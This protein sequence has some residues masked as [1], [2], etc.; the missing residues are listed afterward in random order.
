MDLLDFA[1]C[2]YNKRFLLHLYISEIS[3]YMQFPNFKR[4]WNIFLGIYVVPLPSVDK[5]LCSIPL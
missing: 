1:F 2:H 4:R 5:L 3:N